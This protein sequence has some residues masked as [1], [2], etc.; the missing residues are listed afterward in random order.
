MKQVKLKKSG[1]SI[2]FKSV[3]GKGTTFQIYLPKAQPPITDCDKKTV[4]TKGGT[5]TILV[6]DDDRGLVQTLDTILSAEGYKVS[7]APDATQGLQV[8]DSVDPHLIILDLKMP[9]ISGAGFLSRISQAD[10]ALKLKHSR[11]SAQLLPLLTAANGSFSHVVNG[12]C[13]P[14]RG[15]SAGSFSSSGLLFTVTMTSIL[16]AANTIFQFPFGHSSLALRMMGG[17]S[18]A[19]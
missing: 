18:V 12:F 17:S 10:G 4:A 16:F 19:R 8:L 3:E 1:G 2:S 5:E 7:T 14:Q 6:V 11:C 13:G 9:G 15:P